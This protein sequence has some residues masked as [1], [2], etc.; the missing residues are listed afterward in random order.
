MTQDHQLGLLDLAEG[1]LATPNDDL[2]RPA[3]GRQFAIRRGAAFARIGQVAAVLR[4]FS[5]DGVHYTETWPDD[6]LPPLGCGMVLMPWPNRVAGGRWV[7][8][9]T[10][11]QL[12]ITEPGRGNAIH[13]LLRNTAYQPVRLTED[14]V[15][16]A[17]PVYPQHGWPFSLDTAVTYTVTDDGLRV[18]HTVGNV[19][20]APALFGCGAHPYLRIG[21]VPTGDLTLTIRAA[22]RIVT[23]SGMIPTATEPLGGELAALPT[24][25]R[26]AGLDVDIGLADLEPVAGRYEH[27]LLAPQGR[28]LVLWA[29]PAFRWVQLF[30]PHGFPAPEGP[31]Q[32]VAVEPMTCPA[33]ALNSGTGLIALRGGEV[34]SAS[35]GLTP[36]R[37]GGDAGR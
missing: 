12:D 30:T 1:G 21:G 4:E 28:G 34:W 29:D 22:T 26:L 35:W 7:H 8:D 32:A 37:A 13:G 25:A 31:R 33:N 5:F 11:R 3:S 15:T 14:S 20:S 16:L 24:G 17:A 19:G 18:T 9:G 23:D 6:Q 10:E 27:T 2:P 36:F